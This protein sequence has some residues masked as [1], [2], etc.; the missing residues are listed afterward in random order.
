MHARQSVVVCR[1]TEPAG[2]SAK[3]STSLAALFFVASVAALNAWVFSVLAPAF[4]VFVASIFFDF[5]APTFFVFAAAAFTLFLADADLALPPDA[6]FA[7]AFLVTTLLA[8]AVVALF[9][10]ALVAG[11]GYRA[12]QS[13]P[14]ETSAGASRSS[15]WPSAASSSDSTLQLAARKLRK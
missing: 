5:S 1:V 9:F 15:V 10:L 8:L 11:I 13:A 7:F 4:F 14:M 3:S 6:G 12:V 2:N